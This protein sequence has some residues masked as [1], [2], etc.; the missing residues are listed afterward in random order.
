MSVLRRPSWYSDYACLSNA[1]RVLRR[2][3]DRLVLAVGDGDPGPAIR[4]LPWDE[5]VEVESAT[6]SASFLKCLDHALVTAD[7]ND[8]IYMVEQDYLHTELANE[9]LDDGF[10]VRPSGYVGLFDDPLYYWRSSDTPRIPSS[11]R[12]FAGAARHWRSAP[13]TTMTFAGPAWLFAD[14][15]SVVSRYLSANTIPPDSVI[16][17]E[18][19]AAGRELIVCVPG[20]ATHVETSALTPY[21]DWRA[22][23][24]A[25]PPARDQLP[26][27][28]RDELCAV[29]SVVSTDSAISLA[30]SVF[31]RHGVL[32]ETLDVRTIFG[33]TPRWVVLSADEKEAFDDVVR[34][35]GSAVVGVF[36]VGDR[37]SYKGRWYSGR[38]WFISD[39]AEAM[40]ARRADK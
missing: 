15:Y 40:R 26:S 5:V 24:E 25:E 10:L 16:W 8:Q 6:N 34:N 3:G 1:C 33:R 13:S 4:A 2:S 20:G 23:A 17:K 32:V 18:L 27:D 35:R 39:Y 14:D 38:D 36:V 28:W 7:S 19:I 11:S 29:T 9:L 12:L 22:I 37:V 31:G 21:V 30:K